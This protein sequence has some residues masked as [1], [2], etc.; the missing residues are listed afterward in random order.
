MRKFVFFMILVLG[1]AG[2]V[3]FYQKYQKERQQNA[4]IARQRQ[5]AQEQKEKAEAERTEREHREAMERHNEEIRRAREEARIAA[6]RKRDEEKARKEQ[7]KRDAAEQAKRVR[8]ET[9]ASILDKLNGAELRPWKSAPDS[10][11]PDRVKAEATFHCLMP[12]GEGGRMLLEQK[13][14]FGRTVKVTRIDSQKENEAFEP[15]SF[16]RTVVIFPNMLIAGDRVYFRPSH[17]EEDACRVPPPG[18]T[19]DPAEHDFGMA[20]DLVKEIRVKTSAFAYD[21]LFQP[22]DNEKDAIR[23]ATVSFGEKV[24]YEQFRDKVAAWA[25]HNKAALLKA[26]K[27]RRNT[28]RKVWKP[29][30]VFTDKAVVKKRVDGVIEVPRTYVPRSNKHRYGTLTR[31][32]EN[33][34]RKEEI[35]RQKWQALYDK[36]KADEEKALALKEE[37]SGKKSA[38]GNTGNA[39]LDAGTVV[40][41]LHE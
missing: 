20:Y 37:A 18:E 35:A 26:Q 10:D 32:Y 19:F 38:G 22:F 41:R 15:E 21:V 2:T 3:V 28:P 25:K 39:L 4:E 14:D 34:A 16:N 40:Y 27:Q 12:D 5:L 29:S 31:E 1:L 24:T 23:I 11:R 9:C 33:E 6:Q 36:A 8:H 17:A 30:Y 13:V 7:E